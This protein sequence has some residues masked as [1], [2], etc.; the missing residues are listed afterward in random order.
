MVVARIRFAYGGIV[1][2]T[3]LEPHVRFQLQTFCSAAV[4]R[5]PD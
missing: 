2:E 1:D 3:W 5:Q 4:D